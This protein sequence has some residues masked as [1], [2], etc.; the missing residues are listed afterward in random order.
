MLNQPYIHAVGQCLK[1]SKR[2]APVSR[3]KSPP[4][5]FLMGFLFGPIG[6]GLYLRSFTDFAVSGAMVVAGSMLTVGIGAPLFWCLCGLWAAV[7]VAN[8]NSDSSPPSPP[9]SPSPPSS[10]AV[11][12]PY[13]SGR[14]NCA[15]VSN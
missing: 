15:V 1:Q 3:G 2:L 11:S 12:A 4:V 8:S 10:I 9:T 14:H 7:R 13:T 6:V 5:A